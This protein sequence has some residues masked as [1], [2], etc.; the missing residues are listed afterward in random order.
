MVAACSDDG[1]PANESEGDF[2]GADDGGT[3]VSET[4]GTGN[5]ASG[6]LTD[7]DT[8]PAGSTGGDDGTSADGSTGVATDG[9]SSG[10]TGAQPTTCTS[11][12]DC[13][14]VDDCCSCTAIGVDDE[15]PS[16][17][18][19]ECDQST[20]SMYGVD[21][22]A[23]CELGSCELAP[24][25]CDPSAVSCDSLPPECPDGFVPSTDPDGG[26]WT[27]VCVPAELCD[28][29][30]SCADCPEDEACVEYVAQ[31]GPVAHCSPI[32]EECGGTPSC[33]CMAEVCVSPFDACGDAP[34]GL[35]CGCPVCG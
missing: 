15:P 30:P 18:I 17:D 19:R 22:L 26:C 14:V 28:V 4:G 25:S 9:S 13:I 29:V 16:C 21:P 6:T 11:D 27:N 32:P 12:G 1:A 10:D 35:S 20:C 34:D 5:T 24:V 2:T 23:Q 8:G 3:A 33:A 31:L 7:G